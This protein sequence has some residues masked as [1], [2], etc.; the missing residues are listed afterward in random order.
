MQYW[1]E[2]FISQRFWNRLYADGCRASYDCVCRSAT[3]QD[4]KKLKQHP[5]EKLFASRSLTFQLT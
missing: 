5:Q 4:I 3:S 2:N 1:I